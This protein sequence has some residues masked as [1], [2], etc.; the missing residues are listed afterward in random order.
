MIEQ[1]FYNYLQYEK[2]FSDH[3]M[4][5]YQNDLKQFDK[6]LEDK[7]NIKNASEANHFHIRSWMV[8]LLQ[9]KISPK[10]INRKLSCLNTYYK[11]LL[12]RK[13]IDKNPMRKVQ[14]P[15]EK[16]SLP[17]F[18]K[19]ES[20]E[21]LF[22]TIP[23]S[24]DFK[25]SRD[26]AILKTLYSCG[27]RRAELIYLKIKDVDFRKQELKVLGKRNKERIIPFGTDLLE[28]LNDYLDE[29]EKLFRNEDEDFL[30]ITQKGKALYPKKVYIIVN[31]YLSR[32][33]TNEFKNPHILRH[34][35]ATH[36]SNNG[37]SLNAIK[38][39]LGHSNL[40][41]T[42]IYTHNSIE[43]LKEVYKKAHPKANEN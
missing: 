19:M 28:S 12:K 9:E 7:C 30:F 17:G 13:L 3:T 32:V 40:A 43:K 21:K 33:T 1:S 42:Q 34:S 15:K 38:E 35:F 22:N 6:F 41:A 14:G 10:S 20:L 27:L 39:L 8:Q 11:Y 25:G 24:K 4:K 31:E 26:H 18:I 37:A 23:F 36:L 29:R 5:A 2:R 16:K